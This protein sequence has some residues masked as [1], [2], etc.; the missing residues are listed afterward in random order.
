MSVKRWIA[1]LVAVLL[2][3]S[4]IGLALIYMAMEENCNNG[5]DRWSCSGSVQSL[6]DG[7][8]LGIPMVFLIVLAVVLMRAWVERREG[9]RL[10]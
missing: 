3:E 10:P 8:L 7:A 6:L 9:T 4:G 2:V 1:G 5:N